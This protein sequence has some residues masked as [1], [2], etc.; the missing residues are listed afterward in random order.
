MTTIAW[1]RKSGYLAADS[2]HVT[3]NVHHYDAPKIIERNGSF[4]ASM[5][6]VAWTEA[7]IDWDQDGANP[8][9]CPLTTLEGHQ[10]GIVRVRDGVCD[11]LDFRLPYWT[12]AAE[13]WAVGTGADFALTAMECG[14]NPM[15]AV[16]IAAKFDTNTGGPVNFIHVD[17]VD[18]GVMTYEP[19]LIVGHEVEDFDTGL[20]R[21]E[22]SSDASLIMPE[23][24]DVLAGFKQ[25]SWEGGILSHGIGTVRYHD[26]QGAIGYEIKEFRTSV[27]TSRGEAVSE[28]KYMLADYLAAFSKGDMI[29]WR[30]HPEVDSRFNFNHDVKEFIGYARLCVIPGPDG[31]VLTSMEHGSAII[32]KPSKAQAG[33]E[34]DLWMPECTGRLVRYSG[35]GHCLRCNREWHALKRGPHEFVNGS[36]D[37]IR[38]DAATVA[39]SLKFGD[40]KRIETVQKQPFTVDTKGAEPLTD[41]WRQVI[42]DAV[43]TGNLHEGYLHIAGATI[44]MLHDLRVWV[45]H[46]NFASQAGDAVGLQKLNAKLRT[47]SFPDGVQ[48][49][50]E[51]PEPGRPHWRARLVFD[52]PSKA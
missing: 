40:G 41:D 46:Y 6:S 29:V 15:E 1:N 23:L 17:N 52:E 18:C 3:G 25:K 16:M 26:E 22:L 50:E 32:H 19:D 45:K 10:G 43:N 14:K 21:M 28:L 36:R 47:M 38:I 31:V 42:V 51:A 20:A 4:Y 44:D 48:L 5:G 13:R 12:T 49:V 39:Q 37:I 2:R 27:K 24:T 7:W 30:V 9:D 11:M 34:L 8:K 33:G 35:C